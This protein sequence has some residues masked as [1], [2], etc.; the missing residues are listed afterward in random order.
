[1]LTGPAVQWHADQRL[2]LAGQR[3]SRVGAQHRRLRRT[4]NGGHGRTE[5][6]STY[7]PGV[8]LL[9]GA[10]S[11]CGVHA[12]GRPR[13]RRPPRSRAGRHARH[14]PPPHRSTPHHPVVGRR[15]HPPADRLD[16]ERRRAHPGGR[17]DA[18]G[19]ERPLHRRSRPRLEWLV[20]PARPVRHN[21]ARHVPRHPREPGSTDGHQGTFDHTRRRGR[22]ALGTGAMGI[23]ELLTS[24][25]H[26]VPAGRDRQRSSPG[27]GTRS[28]RRRSGG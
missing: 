12:S 25:D 14:P 26:T 10:L 21:G 23:R 15:L 7:G 1:M 8:A 27:S 13:R 28:R 19:A 11:A 18:V 9:T 24:G 5:G 17:H 2:E 6:I 4:T 20:R 22:V 16:R 3:R